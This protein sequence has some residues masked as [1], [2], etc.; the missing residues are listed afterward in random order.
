VPAVTKPRPLGPS[1]FAAIAKFFWEGTRGS[2]TTH[3]QSGYILDSLAEIRLGAL[4]QA[5]A[6]NL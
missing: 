2:G 4:T 6:N 3:V 5:T 1:L